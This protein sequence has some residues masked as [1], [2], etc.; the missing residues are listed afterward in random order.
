MQVEHANLRK[1]DADAVGGL[2]RRVPSQAIETR[3]RIQDRALL[4]L[5]N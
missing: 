2:A 1:H 4:C 5:N 3:A